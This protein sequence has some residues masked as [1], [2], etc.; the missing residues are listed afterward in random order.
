MV[1]CGKLPECGQIAIHAIK[2]KLLSMFG[3]NKGGATM[4]VVPW[5]AI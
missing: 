1:G 2:I 5:S 4:L 3:V